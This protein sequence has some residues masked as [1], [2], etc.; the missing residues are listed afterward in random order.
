[1]KIMP[2]LAE[3]EES[4]KTRVACLACDFVVPI[5]EEVSNGV[6]AV[7]EIVK[8]DSACPSDSEPSPS[9][10]PAKSDDRDQMN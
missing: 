10:A 7:A 5:T 3:S 9:K 6:N 4:K 8:E 1:M 2:A